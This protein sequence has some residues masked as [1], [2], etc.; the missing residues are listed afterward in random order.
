MS[1][2]AT[3]ADI[4]TLV[5]AAEARVSEAS[6][7]RIPVAIVGAGH[8]AKYHMAVLRQ[9]GGV[10][11]VGA[12]DPSQERLDALC[13]EWQI[14]NR[15]SSLEEL[16]RICRPKVVH[17]LV[18]PASHYEVTRQALLAGLHVLVE[19]PMALVARE[20]DDLIRLAERQQLHLGVND[21][22][23]Y[24]PAFQRL[25]SD[26]KAGKLGRVEHV[27]SMNNLPLAQLESGEHDHWMFHQTTNVLFEQ[28]PHPLSQVCEL[29]GEVERVGVMTSGRRTL[30]TG[31]LFES[32]WQMALGCKR[33][34]AD[35]FLAFGRTFPEAFLHVIGQ[36]GSAHVDLI[37][38]TYQLDQATKF[39][40][41]GDRFLRRLRQSWQIARGGLAGFLRYGL[42][43]LGILKR[44]DPYY[45]SML[46]CA[47]AYYAG[48]KQ[49]ETSPSS[50]EKGLWV[51]QGLEA[52]AA[53][54]RSQTAATCWIAKR[55]DNGSIGSSG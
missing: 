1:S 16:L 24:H 53:C 35:L 43:T 10:D 45:A 48:F 2:V 20:C 40:D 47:R 17:V 13:K 41:A 51:I 12:C 25:L 42:S 22:A 54:Y 36:D 39:I 34:T 18:P 52:A 15:A 23:V 33:G 3:T 27:V 38:N 49:Q 55:S 19:K 44:T 21:N 29:L 31:T 6:L 32:C 46:G 26:I 37:N 30:R 8:I 11:V 28:G 7:E 4:S 5:E 50:A 14:P 9:L